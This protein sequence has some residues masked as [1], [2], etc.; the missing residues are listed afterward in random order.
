MSFTDIA[1]GAASSAIGGATGAISSTVSSITSQ[2]GGA[3]SAISSTV[4]GAAGSVT[5][6]LASLTGGG[7]GPGAAGAP[8]SGG[9]TDPFQSK[10]DNRLSIVRSRAAKV[11]Y[12]NKGKDTYTSDRGPITSMKILPGPGYNPVNSVKGARSNVVDDVNAL[13]AGRFVNFFLTDVQC[14]FNEKMQIIQTFGDNEIVYYFGKQPVIMNISGLLFDSLEND[15]FSK[16]L[17]MYAGVLRGTQLAQ[18]FSLIQI[19]FP[20]MVVK[21]SISGFSFNQN[22]QRDTDIPFQM[23]F[24]AK[25]VVPLPVPV[26]HGSVSNLQ[27]TLVDWKADRQGVAGY[28]LSSG[29]L[30]SGFMDSITKTVGS[31]GS[32]GG[33]IGSL[34]GGLGSVLSSASSVGSALSDFRT[35]IFS[36]V[37]GVISSI[38]KIVKSVT[39]DISSIISS[40]TNPIN[41]VLRD[42]TSI[43]SKASSLASMVEHSINSVLSVPGRIV[44]DIK[45]TIRALERSAGTITRVPEN[46]SQSFKRMYGSGNLK[47]GSSSSLLSGGKNGTVSKR[48]VLSSGAPYVPSKSYTL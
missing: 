48:A 27:G 6:A 34:T 24:V 35:N 42:I 39:G 28:S 37:Y 10:D 29:G 18:T 17:T 20:N 22:S 4:S 15:W 9:T 23:T 11:L 12:D 45:G 41:Q 40:F 7:S 25:E 1:S 26:V 14:A 33:T 3:I 38:T 30:G 43:A 19:T 5:G 31:L 8:A 36:P 46:I 44:A 32:I 13:V 2:A 16:F 47:H 21:G